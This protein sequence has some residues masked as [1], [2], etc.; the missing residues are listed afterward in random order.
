M[1]RIQNGA[2]SGMP[3]G[4]D[5]LDRIIERI[6]KYRVDPL[7]SDE[8]RK[9]NAKVPPTFR[10]DSQILRDL[11]LVIAYSQGST[12]DLVDKLDQQ[13]HLDKVFLKYDIDKVAALNPCDL[14]DTVE[15]WRPIAAIRKKAKVFHVVMAARAIKKTK[16]RLRELLRPASLAQRISRPADILSFHD[17]FAR[18]QAEIKDIDIPF[19]HSTTSLLHFL[20]H[21][22]YDC[23]KPDTKVVQVA[24]ELGWISNKKTVSDGELREI[25]KQAQGY[26]LARG[27]RPSIVDL[28]MLIHG[29]QSWAKKFVHREY[30]AAD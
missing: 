17:E 6:E 4:Y 1:K 16:G 24:R 22:G 20:M 28:Y 30:Y 5:K 25:V 19:L 29:D 23:V 13:G 27:I 14:V 21:V 11:V 3:I 26:A 8:I 2:A 12:S 18:I 15:K 9:R 7:L 10:R